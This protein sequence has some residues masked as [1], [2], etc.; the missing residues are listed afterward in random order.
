M[1]DKSKR[2]SNIGQVG[3]ASIRIA[4]TK[5]EDLPLVAGA[6]ARNQIAD[7]LAHEKRNKIAT[8]RAKYPPETIAYL[9]GWLRECTENIERIKIVKLQQSEI[10]NEY[11][12]HISMC[13]YR[14]EEVAKLDENIPGDLEQIKLLKKRFPPYQVGKMQ[15]QIQMC[16]EALERCD[17]VIE[18]EFKSIAMLQERR[19]MCEFRDKE[20]KALGGK[21]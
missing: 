16:R 5:I 2:S 14:D 20:L 17:D 7:A 9:D 4:Q 13:S 10:I 1:A 18:A 21:V 19:G 15:D 12:G 11:T 3:V 6:H 8:V